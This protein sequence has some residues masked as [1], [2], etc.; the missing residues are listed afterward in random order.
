M[1]RPDAAELRRDID[2]LAA[3]TRAEHL[4]LPRVLALLDL[5]DLIDLRAALLA[6]FRASLAGSE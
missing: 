2:A 4:A 6:R 5:D 3:A 1:S